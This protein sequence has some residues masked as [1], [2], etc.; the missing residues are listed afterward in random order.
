VT[1]ITIH[2][3][4]LVVLIDL[5]ESGKSSFTHKHFNPTEILSSNY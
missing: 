1:D 5:S 4:S 3:L 2:E